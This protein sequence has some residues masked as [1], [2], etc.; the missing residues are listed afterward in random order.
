M[1][2]EGRTWTV[3]LQWCLNCLQIDNKLVLV[4]VL[5]SLDALLRSNV[6]NIPQKVVTGQVKSVLERFK[7]GTKS[8]DVI[9]WS[10]NCLEACTI[11]KS[12]ELTSQE[13]FNVCA[14]VFLHYLCNNSKMDE[15]SQSKV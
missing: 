14:T 3:T 12:K 9:L 13:D 1:V 5:L 15:I 7:G 2:V 6:S 8:N 4:D 10:C 11:T